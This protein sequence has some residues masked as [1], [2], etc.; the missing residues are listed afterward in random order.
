MRTSRVIGRLIIYDAD[1][2]LDYPSLYHPC[3][4]T[5]NHPPNF[6]TMAS[7]HPADFD[8]YTHLCEPGRN[9]GTPDCWH[10]PSV[11]L[12][13]FF[14]EFLR[15]LVEYFFLTDLSS[16]RISSCRVPTPETSTSI[17]P[18]IPTETSQANALSRSEALDLLSISVVLA[19]CIGQAI[20][21][22]NIH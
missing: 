16:F 13:S 22:W 11:G 6:N 5:G 4:G 12:A 8:M 9:G 10:D 18:T 20:A 14:E 19:A 2:P 21:Y 3:A 15:F 17:E 1:P 7:I